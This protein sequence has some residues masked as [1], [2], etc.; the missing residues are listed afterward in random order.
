M[1]TITANNKDIRLWSLP[2]RETLVSIPKAHKSM[3]KDIAFVPTKHSSAAD[4]QASTSRRR[5]EDAIMSNTPDEDMMDDDD[6]DAQ[7]TGTTSRFLSCSADKT[8]KLW[9]AHTLRADAAA[10]GQSKVSTKALNTYL[11][12]IGFK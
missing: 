3:V 5:L 6:A 9:D 7:E 8:I 4:G 10:A 2:T 12:R 11:G 1:L